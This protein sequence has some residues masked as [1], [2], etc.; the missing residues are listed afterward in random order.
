MEIKATVANRTGEH[1]VTVATNG[2]ERLLSIPAKATQPGSAVNGGELLFAALATCFCN[3]VYREAAKRGITISDVRV[4]VTGEFGG[5]GE[6]ARNIRYH[7]SV[8]SNAT[9]EQIRDL[10]NATDR[11]AEIQNTVRQGAKIAFNA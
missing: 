7:A 3:D 1:V 6:P 4:E 11:V 2:N 5:E 10:L 9:P 8:E